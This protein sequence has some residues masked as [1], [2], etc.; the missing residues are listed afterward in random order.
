MNKGW[1]VVVSGTIGGLVGL[2]YHLISAQ[3]ETG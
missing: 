3:M 2:G 1:Q